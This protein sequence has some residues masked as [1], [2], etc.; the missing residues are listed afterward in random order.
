MLAAER[1]ITDY[2]AM[3][4]ATRTHLDQNSMTH[5]I[6][7]CNFLTWVFNQCQSEVAAEQF[8]E[9]KQ[10]A[11]LQFHTGLLDEQLADAMSAKSEAFS[12]DHLLLVKSLL[13]KTCRESRADVERREQAE[14]DR[15]L[16][17]S[18][19]V[20]RPSSLTFLNWTPQAVAVDPGPQYRTH[21]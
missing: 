18:K 20:D 11:M 15:V 3:P 5:L 14:A 19:Q 4:P 10:S 8:S 2:E 21:S 7:M 12:W 9:I 1:L 16:Q 6:S 13:E 17:D